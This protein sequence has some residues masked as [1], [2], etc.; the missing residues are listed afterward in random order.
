MWIWVIAQVAQDTSFWPTRLNDWLQA[1]AVYV[2]AIVAAIW[3]LW[4]WLMK[5]LHA[6]IEAEAAA[7]KKADEDR[8]IV[9]RK[10]SDDVHT[11]LGRMTQAEQAFA[12]ADQDRAYMH[13][14]IGRIDDTVKQLSSAQLQN[15]RD[16]ARELSTIR[17][18][19]AKIMGKLDI[20]P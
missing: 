13:E 14:T 12:L 6:E 16:R 10:L 5:P 18:G 3:G 4:Q 2:V 17:E 8:D 1:V 20:D 11:V 7:R 9:Q 15:D 19:V